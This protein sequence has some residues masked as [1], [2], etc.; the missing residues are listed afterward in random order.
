[1]HSVLALGTRAV[2]A[3]APDTA[4]P[5]IFLRLYIF[6]GL[7]VVVGIAWFVLRGYREPGDKHRK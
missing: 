2:L 5:G 1:M 7:A 6:G 3:V 4:P